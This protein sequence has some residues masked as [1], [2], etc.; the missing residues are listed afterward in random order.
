MNVLLFIFLSSVMVSM[1]VALGSKMDMVRDAAASV[2]P[3]VYPR[4][5]RKELPYHFFLKKLIANLNRI[6]S[7]SDL[8][9]V[10]RFCFIFLYLE[11]NLWLDLQIWVTSPQTHKDWWWNNCYLIEWQNEKKFYLTRTTKYI[12]YLFILFLFVS[13]CHSIT[14][15]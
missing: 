13:F 8:S 2:L 12:M 10:N 11:K 9:K 15:P 4:G 14:N 5:H 7:N 3:V 1:I 6:K